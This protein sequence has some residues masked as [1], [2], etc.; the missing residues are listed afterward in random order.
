MHIPEPP[1][2]LV[3]DDGQPTP[4]ALAYEAALDAEHQRIM[5]SIPPMPKRDILHA[6]ADRL[7]PD[8]AHDR[9]KP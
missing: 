7:D 2:H 3:D 8:G 1:E 9:S 5:A 6:I 4:E